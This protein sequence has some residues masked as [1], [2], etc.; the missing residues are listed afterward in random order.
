MLSCGRRRLGEAW[1]ETMRCVPLAAFFVMRD[2]LNFAFF[3]L[4]LRVMI[5]RCRIPC[6]RFC[7]LGMSRMRSSFVVMRTNRGA[8]RASAD[9]LSSHVLE[10]V[11]P[12]LSRRRDP[13]QVILL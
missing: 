13:C 1:R 11:S 7:A 10:F 2:W 9:L 6:L 3:I 12:V 8:P 5:R 4:V